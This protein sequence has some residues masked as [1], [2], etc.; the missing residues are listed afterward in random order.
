[1]KAKYNDQK[2][3]GHLGAFLV[4]CLNTQLFKNCPQ[5]AWTDGKFIRN[6]PGC[7]L[8]FTHSILYFVRSQRMQSITRHD[9]EMPHHC[10]YSST[11]LIDY[12]AVG[13][14]HHC[15]CRTITTW[16]MHTQITRKQNN[17]ALNCVRRRETE[18]YW[19]WN[20][21]IKT[22]PFTKPLACFF[23]YTEAGGP[24]KTWSLCFCSLSLEAYMM[25]ATVELEVWKC[26]RSTAIIHPLI[27][28]FVGTILKKNT[29][30][31]RI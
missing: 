5:S 24:G 26:M 14:L 4:A 27:D 9:I 7:R 15:Q 29:T 12:A 20:I 13:C 2:A 16:I 18:T 23:Y 11:R 30:K 17:H 10:A 31:S 1:M 3:C 22:T 28:V 21:L 25:F 8:L 6:L 19:N